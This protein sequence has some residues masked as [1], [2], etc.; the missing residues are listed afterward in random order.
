MADQQAIQ[1]LFDV[2]YT[3]ANRR[4]TALKDAKHKVAH[5]TAAANALSIIKGRTLWM[6]NAALMND[7]LEISFGKACLEAAITATGSAFKQLLDTAHVGLF[8]EV[9]GWVRQ[10]DAT[11]RT[12]TYLTAFA[13][14]HEDDDLG[15]L[16]M[17]RAYGGPVAGVALI[18][19]TD[20]FENED[21]E[22]N[23]SALPVMYGPEKFGAE[24][25]SFLSRLIAHQ[26]LL[27]S[28]PRVNAKSILFHVLQDFVLSAKHEGFEEEQEWR[29][30]YSPFIARSEFLEEGIETVSGIPQ[31]VYKLPLCNARG[32]KMP[33]LELDRLIHK[34]LIGPCEYPQQVAFAISEAL[35][36]H[37]VAKPEARTRFSGIPLRQS[38]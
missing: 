3:H 17:W 14:I 7:F 10:V 20:A 24:F 34:V 26:H 13:E 16:S 32:L 5:Y 4:L 19:N 12:Q 21:A 38:R 18:F 2:A 15:K 1:G 22:M 33:E 31:M 30:I 29:A 36:S 9:L 27:G 23:V 25:H 37:G 28:V 8:E 11:T 6:R 35:K